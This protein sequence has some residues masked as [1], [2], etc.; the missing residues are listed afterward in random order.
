MGKPLVMSAIGGAAEQ[1]RD[2][3]NGY[4]FP[5]GD[6]GALTAALHKL[7]DRRHCAELGVRARAIVA[8]DFGLDRMLDRYARLLGEDLPE[9]G[10][11]EFHAP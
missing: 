5:A 6:V 3:E 11:H 9:H 10:G 8:R 2:G 7:A 1:V 4:L